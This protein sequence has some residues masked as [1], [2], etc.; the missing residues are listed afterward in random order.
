MKAIIIFA[1]Q[2]TPMESR[3]SISEALL[4]TL[5]PHRKIPAWWGMFLA[6]QPTQKTKMMSSAL[7]DDCK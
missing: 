6:T 5:E 7:G 3:I 4:S 1:Q 2:K